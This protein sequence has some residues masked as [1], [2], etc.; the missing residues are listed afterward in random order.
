MCACVF[1]RIL[2]SFIPFIN[3]FVDDVWDS[4]CLRVNKKLLHQTCTEFGM[5]SAATTDAT[6]ETTA[7]RWF[8]HSRPIAMIFAGGNPTL[9]FSLALPPFPPSS[10]PYII[11]SFSFFLPTI[12]SVIPFC[13]AMGS[14]GKVSRVLPEPLGPRRRWPAIL[15]S[16]ARHQPKLPTCRTVCLFTSY[17]LRW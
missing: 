17:S 6:E 8:I 11:S 13:T 10:S 7:W 9:S 3:S 14:V 15:W 16:S 5:K 4:L 1:T 12:F 2:N